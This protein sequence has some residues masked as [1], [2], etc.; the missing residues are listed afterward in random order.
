V[1][2]PSATPV[3]GTSAAAGDWVAVV[4][5]AARAVAVVEHH[6][7]ICWQPKPGDDALAIC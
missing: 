3:T 1:V 7:P 5:V 6:P 2:L 4:R